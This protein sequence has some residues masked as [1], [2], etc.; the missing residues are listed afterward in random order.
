MLSYTER[1]N[2]F[3]SLTKDG[4]TANLLIGDR[5]MNS[6]VREVVKK[7][8]FDFLK[9]TKTALTEAS[10]QFYKL[11]YDC[12][13]L[14]SPPTITIAGTVYTPRKCSSREEWDRLN[15]NTNITSNI[16]ERYIVFGG[17]VGFYPK[18]SAGSNT[19]TFVYSKLVKD[20][21]IADYTT[22]G[23]LTT[24]NAGASIVGTGTSWAIGMAGMWLR[25]TDDTAAN[26]G[27][28]VW[29]E[30]DSVSSTTAL[31]LEKNYEG[32]SIAAGNA[33]YTIG[34]MSILPYGF[35]ILPVYRACQIYHSTL[36]PDKFLA[37]EFK[38]LYRESYLSL[39]ENHSLETFDPVILDEE[40]EIINPNLSVW[41]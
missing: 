39:I 33:G 35:G 19:I 4:S 23:I 27:D 38:E 18:P 28:G 11:P 36:K 3:G 31:T 2:L 8:P 37:A 7:K 26:K 21:S 14:I 12:G 15:Q 30:I 9:K 29:Y 32:V 41:L 22:G 13:K 20:L 24:T 10:V 5:L 25:I 16:P 34:Q 6:V 1:R 40:V 17:Q